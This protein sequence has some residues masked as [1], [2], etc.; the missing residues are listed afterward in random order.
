MDPFTIA[1]LVAMLA[2]T[3]MQA[4]ASSDAK[5]RSDNA[6]L[7]ALQR[8]Q[9]L[10]QE[11]EAK[12]LSTAQE[13]NG[14]NRAANQAQLEAE[15]TEEFIRPVE[16]AQQINSAASTTQGSVSKDYDAAKTASDVNQMKTAHALAKLFGKT[17]A[18]G[19]LRQNEALKMSDAASDIGT[20][21]SFAAGRS[22]AD[23]IS[24]AQ[25]GT[26]RAGLMLGGQLVS[27]IGSVGLATGGG[28]AAP[29]SSSAATMADWSGKTGG[30]GLKPY[31]SV[32]VTA[33]NFPWSTT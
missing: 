2:G 9:A 33:K 1:S 6:T 24:I 4:K 15:L 3:A 29:Q 23:D 32:G 25:A 8:Q 12:A 27:G 13:F 7:A 20:L 28:G 14:D 22:R 31:G 18:A 30:L 11:A 16:N 5:K 17:T 19:R 21:R 10:Q 26:P